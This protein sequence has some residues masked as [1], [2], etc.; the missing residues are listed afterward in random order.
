MIRLSDV[1]GDDDAAF[2][3]VEAGS[4][5]ELKPGSRAVWTLPKPGSWRPMARSPSV[6][7]Q[8]QTPARKAGGSDAADCYA[9]VSA[10]RPRDGCCRLS[11]CRSRPRS[12][13]GAATA[14]Q[15]LL[16]APAPGALPMPRIGARFQAQLLTQRLGDYAM[17]A[18]ERLLQDQ[19]KRIRSPSSSRR[20]T[21]PIVPAPHAPRRP[22]HG[23]ADRQAPSQ[24]RSQPAPRVKYN[25]Y[26]KLTDVGESLT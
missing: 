8:H 16:A 1:A 22:F 3:S 10:G 18:A 11:G 24:P 2:G 17:Q 23:L 19:K 9:A 20:P 14:T 13:A 7:S 21:T 4:P 25:A 6:Y 26:R 5:R 15:A 12:A